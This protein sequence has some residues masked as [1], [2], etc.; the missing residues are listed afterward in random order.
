MRSEFHALTMRQAMSVVPDFFRAFRIHQQ[1]GRTQARLEQ[2][3]LDDLSPGEVVIRVSTPA[4]I[5]RMRWPP[6]APADPA[7]LSAGGRRRPAGRC[8]RRRMRASAPATRCCASA[9][10]CRRRCDGGYSEIARMPAGLVLPMPAWLDAQSAMAI[11][12]AGFTAALA[13]DATR[14]QRTGAGQ[15]PVPVTGAAGGVGSLAIDML[16]ARGYEVV[17]VTRPARTRGLA[18]CA[19]RQR[20]AAARGTAARRAAA[21]PGAL[22]RRHRQCRRRDPA[23]AA[24]RHA[25]RRQRR[26][27]RPG[28]RRGAAHHRDAL[29]PAR[30]E[31]AGHELFRDHGGAAAAGVA[32]ARQ[33]PAAAAPG[34]HPHGASFPFDALPG[35]FQPYLDGSVRGRQVVRIG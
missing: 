6:P 31:P 29:H 25:Q 20:A 7:A 11:G 32:A 12:T 16:A 34:S 3:S 35:A 19:G 10:D 4:S 15:G 33:R 23:C 27:R 5:T 14:T 1:D 30:R 28:G 26:Q 18:A 22:G 24:G 8:S 17:A 21:G 2:L 9:A 13:I